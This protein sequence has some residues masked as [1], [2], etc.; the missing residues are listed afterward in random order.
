MA[1]A[2]LTDSLPGIG[3][4]L[5]ESPEDFRVEEIPFA[6]PGGGGEHL[7]LWVEKRGVSTIEAL[8]ALC[9]ALDT[10]EAEAGYAGL[11]D[12]NAVTKQWFSFKTKTQKIPGAVSKLEQ[13]GIRVLEAARS[14][15]RIRRG[16]LSGNR[17]DIVIRDVAPGAKLKADE[18]LDCLSARGLP[19]A[20]GDQRF[21]VHG[22]T[23]RVG[24]A[25]AR[26]DWRGVLDAL[27]G[28][29]RF[30][31]TRNDADERLLEA[32]RRYEAGE[33]QR[34]GELYPPSWEAE[35]RALARLEKGASPRQ[36][37]ASIPLRERVLY[38][39]A[40]Q[41]C[42]FNLCLAGRLEARAHDRLWTG[43]VVFHHET[44]KARR[45][46]AP[47]AEACSL[48]RFEVS[49]AGPLI[50]RKLIGARGEAGKLERSVLD[51]LG[52]RDPEILDGLERLKLYGS[53]RPYRVQMKEVSLR[54][55]E[56]LRLGFTL[57]PGS[58]ASEVLR[59]LTKNEPPVGAVTR[60]GGGH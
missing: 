55:E 48:A 30:A 6:P 32:A 45:V 42:V 15:S 56:G 41:A 50:G 33:F 21:G 9:R 17:F 4:R 8:R 19:N 40:L 37:A 20:F 51:S 52:I 35:R 1:G 53:R 14:R 23:A 16:S 7:H 25:F 36:A 34:A 24:F 49:P 43:D 39:G 3:G 27:L 29:A 22:H 2:Y 60:I 18:I 28:G 12:A 10:P 5:R 58:Y 57:P 47:E 11:K 54:Q 31:S 59:E 46:G 38:G 13:G 26:G 44:G